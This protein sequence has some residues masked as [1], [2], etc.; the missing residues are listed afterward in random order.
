VWTITW[1]QV[2]DKGFNLKAYSQGDP[3]L[4]TATFRVE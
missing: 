3:M 2:L 1:V 4:A